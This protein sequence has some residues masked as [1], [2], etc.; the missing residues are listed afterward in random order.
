MPL[1][2][3]P[4]W[5]SAACETA[6]A[7]AEAWVLVGP[8]MDRQSQTLRESILREIGRRTLQPFAEACED[9]KP[10]FYADFGAARWGN[11]S[12]MCCGGIAVACDA[13]AGLGRDTATARRHAFRALDAYVHR[14]F[15]EHGE[16]D[17]GLGVVGDDADGPGSARGRL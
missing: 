17:E 11:W 7:L 16:C 6:A 8:W 9:G 4:Q 10:P 2:G 5:D 12:G 1:T 15:T 13:L 14:G 3:T